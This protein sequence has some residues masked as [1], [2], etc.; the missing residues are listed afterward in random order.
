MCIGYESSNFGQK[1]LMKKEILKSIDPRLL[2]CTRH[3]KTRPFVIYPMTFF[4]D[5]TIIYNTYYI[6]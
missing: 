5:F 2:K 1:L 3:W 6:T 4:I